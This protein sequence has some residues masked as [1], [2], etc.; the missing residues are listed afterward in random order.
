MIK[1]PMCEDGFTEK[2]SVCAACDGEG[3][4][5]PGDLAGHLETLVAGVEDKAGADLDVMAVLVHKIAGVSNPADLQELVRQHQAAKGIKARPSMPDHPDPPS[6]AAET[7]D[8]VEAAEDPP[9]LEPTA[10]EALV[11]AVAA[12]PGVKLDEAAVTLAELDLVTNPADHKELVR[13]LLAAKGIKARRQTR[14]PS[15]SRTRA[16]GSPGARRSW[17]S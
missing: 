16:A 12:Q 8:P 14:V 17:R 3:W 5:A 11:A 4:L 7:P 2:D 1:C 10:L 13:Q 6:T 15:C 9:D